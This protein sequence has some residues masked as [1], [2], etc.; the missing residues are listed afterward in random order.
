M[1]MRNGLITALLLGVGFVSTGATIYAQQ[2]DLPSGSPVKLFLPKGTGPFPVLLM[3]DFSQE[4]DFFLKHGYAVATTGKLTVTD[5]KFVL[6][7]Y[8]QGKSAVRWLRANA[9]LYKLDP[10]RIGVVG[11]SKFGNT[12]AALA[13]T[14]GVKQFSFGNESFDL[15]RGGNFDQSDRVACAINNQGTA[16]LMQTD[17]FG[18][19]AG[20]P[21]GMTPV[22]GIASSP[23]YYLNPDDAPVLLLFNLTGG[24]HGWVSGHRFSVAYD[25]MGLEQTLFPNQIKDWKLVG[26]DYL[27]AHLKDP[28]GPP[29]VQI[30]PGSPASALGP[31]I[32]WFTV[33]R[34]AK[35]LDL[36]LT[37]KYTADTKGACKPLS[38]TVTIPAG[39]TTAQILVEPSAQGGGPIWITLADSPDYAISVNS[40][41]TLKVVTPAENTL[42]GVYLIGTQPF[43]KAST[44]VGKITVARWGDRSKSLLV[45]YD[46]IG[47]AVAGKDYEALPGRIEIPA[48]SRSATITVMALTYPKK[49]D[50][51]KTVA[52][53]VR[54]AKDYTYGPYSQGACVILMD[55]NDLWMP[56]MPDPFDVR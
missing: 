47:N 17:R 46:I 37:V 29:R 18:D 14:A 51:F 56:A 20:G 24:L 23:L 54:P 16:D 40:S 9:R 36:P 49:G 31:E 21:M 42:P 26:L 12:A 55:A 13:T 19:S 30:A 44:G 38:G 28:A 2:V 33:V 8:A 53:S 6:G 52:L 34:F 39:R 15:L 25:Q 43:A 3:I 41:A 1:N 32:G 50:A 35:K 22:S 10:E 45:E 7:A 5:D 11:L 48:G 4:K 27:D